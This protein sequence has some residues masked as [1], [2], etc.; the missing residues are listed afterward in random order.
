MHRR[1]HIQYERQTNENDRS[2]TDSAESL[3]FEKKKPK[4]YKTIL[5]AIFM[6]VAGVVSGYLKF[7]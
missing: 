1:R 3:L 7:N 2:E 6:F 4:P 5:M